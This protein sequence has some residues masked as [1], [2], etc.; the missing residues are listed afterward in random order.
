MKELGLRRYRLII[1]DFDGTLADSFTW[2]TG[3]LA[4]VARRF[5]FRQLTPA[6]IPLLRDMDTHAIPRFLGV[7]RWKYLLIARHLR[8]LSKDAPI[9]LFPGAGTLLKEL[10]AQDYILVLISSNS[11]TTVRRILGEELAGLISHYG[12]SASLFGKAAKF[13]R[14]IERFGIARQLV[15]CVGDETRDLEAGASLGLD[16]GAVTWGYAS[17][18]LLAEHHP[19]FLFQTMKDIPL[20][21]D[22]AG[23]A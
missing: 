2:L 21:L 19:R 7:P 14:A 5:G 22:G 1:F 20:A 13:R 16:V 15:L 23:A 11:E 10:A 8:R 9:H 18:A 4:D 3:V 17:P 6:D 12:C